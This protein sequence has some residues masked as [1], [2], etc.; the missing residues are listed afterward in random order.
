MNDGEILY[1]GSIWKV[2]T[3]ANGGYRVT[4]DLDTAEIPVLRVDDH[5]AVALMR[6]PDE[7]KGTF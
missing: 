7:G 1:H 4:I 5:V 2:T 6:I 3:V